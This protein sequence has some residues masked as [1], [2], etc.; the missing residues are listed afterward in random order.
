MTYFYGQLFAMDAEIAAMFPAALD[1]QRRRFFYALRR[2]AQ[3]QDDPAALARFLERL[4]RA[5]RKNGIRDK[6]FAV[7]RRAL[8]ATMRQFC[9]NGWTEAAE[10]AWAAAFDHAAQVM[11]DAARSEPG[12][13]WWISTVV[14]TEARTPGIA[15]LT[16]QPDQPLCFL[17]GQHVSVQTL[18]WP[19][20]WRTYSIA[21][22]P[23]PDGTI[24]LHVRATEGGMVSHALVHHV[25]A[26]DPLVLGAPAGSMVAD[27]TSR[28]DVLCLAGGTGLAP[29]KA[30]IEAIIT[31]PFS[32][33]GRHREIALYV[34][35]RRQRD[36]YDLAA[37]R[38][39][40]LSY[41]WLQVL[42]AI[43]AEPAGAA[44]AR[45]V[46]P[47]TIP[48]LAA[49]ASWPGRD[50]Y[51][52]GPDEM[53]RKTVRILTGLGAP[54]DRMHYDLPAEDPP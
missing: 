1:S 12:P 15:V 24:T 3:G 10:A 19:R 33:N 16:L 34:G 26:G 20:L 11:I 43:S 30:I 45:D 17:P 41:P 14:R 29:V 23:R 2:I 44:L 31:T 38:D 46:L 9:G 7:F 39:M 42:P 37:L 53:I 36:L 22:A 35:A 32:G 49:K 28:R 48:Q 50:I 52:S 51:I 25:R 5:H 13:A 6:H 18:H 54:R 4:G 47:G 21:N 40:E 8:L 27:V